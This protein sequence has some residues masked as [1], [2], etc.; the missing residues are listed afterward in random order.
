MPEIAIT[1]KVVGAGEDYP[2]L[3]TGYRRIKGGLQFAIALRPHESR[4]LL[5]VVPKGESGGLYHAVDLDAPAS[6]SYTHLT[7]PTNDQV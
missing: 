1:L 6:V 2:R 3:L 4:L 5:A 7:L